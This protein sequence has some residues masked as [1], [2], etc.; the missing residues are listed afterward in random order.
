MPENRDTERSPAQVGRTWD[1]PLESA[2]ELLPTSFQ[3]VRLQ[4]FK[5]ERLLFIASKRATKIMEQLAFLA[6][7][8]LQGVQSPRVAVG[9]ADPRLG[10]VLVSNLFVH[11][12]QDLW[13]EAEAVYHLV[14][15]LVDENTVLRVQLNYNCYYNY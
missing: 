13:R 15:P 8:L 2:K 7:A 9:A 5:P 3:S 14:L 11:V 6:A 10:T 1:R 12:G 4:T